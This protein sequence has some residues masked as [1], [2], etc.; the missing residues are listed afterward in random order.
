[1]IL[2]DTEI[3]VVILG[4]MMAR[5]TIQDLAK[6]ADVSVATVNRVL[7]GKSNVRRGTMEIVLQAAAEIGFYGVGS[8]KERIA[9]ATES[10]EFSILLM[11]SNRHFYRN[12]AT[13]LQTAAQNVDGYKV[14]LHIHH[15]DNLSPNNVAENILKY[16][17]GS[18]GLAIKSA[19]HP[20]IIESIEKVVASQTPVSALISPL[21]ANCP[22]GFVGLDNWKVGRTAAWAFHKMC[23]SPGK[24]GTLV[25]SH[26]YRNQELNETGFRSYFREYNDKFTVLEP[27]YTY[28]TNAIGQEA[29]EKILTENPDLKGLFISGGGMA[30]VLDAIKRAKL[31]NDFIA[32]GYELTEITKN[33]LLENTLTMVISHPLPDIAKQTI[34]SLIHAK[35]SEGMAHDQTFMLP[36]EI[37]TS[38]NI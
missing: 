35:K 30:G 6:T 31:P 7:S 20:L 29:A 16:G 8:I 18:D 10:F 34:Q 12:L 9:A 27:Q 5:P 1:M 14:K 28:E 38:E 32:V 26:R 3:N 15:I 17:I 25:G 37:H 22:V 4:E 33:A 11:Q 21:V 13:E 2:N 23:K 24:I 19:H 36:F